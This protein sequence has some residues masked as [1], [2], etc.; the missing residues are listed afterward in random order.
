MGKLSIPVE[1]RAGLDFAATLLVDT[2]FP[3]INFVFLMEGD[4]ARSLAG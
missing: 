1:L 3:E 4:R 2:A